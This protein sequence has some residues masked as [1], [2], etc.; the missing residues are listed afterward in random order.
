MLFI[1]DYWLVIDRDYFSIEI[2]FPDRENYTVNACL[3]TLHRE[4]QE[5][6]LERLREVTK[7]T[8][9]FVLSYEYFKM[10]VNPYL[11]HCTFHMFGEPIVF[12]LFTDVFTQALGDYLKEMEKLCQGRA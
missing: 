6:M 2:C 12:Y 7:D 4:Q 1:K 8:P 11:I 9:P 10:E 3:T 5:R